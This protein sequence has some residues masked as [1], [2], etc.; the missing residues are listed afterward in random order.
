MSI[1][2]LLLILLL[3][4][5]W[6]GSFIMIKL[7]LSEIPPIFL[8]SARFFFTSFPAIFFLP[9]P[10]I[11]VRNI[12]VYGVIM[13]ALQFALFFVGMQM[14]V[15]PGLAAILMQVHVFFSLFLGIVVFR[16]KMSLL[17][18]IGALISF[19]GIILVGFH[20]KGVSS[21][22]GFFLIVIAALCWGAG[23]AISK[24]MGKVHILSLV[25]WGSMVAW[26]FLLLLSLV[27]EGPKTISTSFQNLTYVSLGAVIYLS[28]FATLFGFALWNW[29]LHHRPLSSVAPFTLLVPVVAMLFSVWF[30]HEPVEWWKILASSLV[31]GGLLLAFLGPY[32]QKKLPVDDYAI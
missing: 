24:K 2:H 16:E 22:Q 13:F 26:P 6:G 11:R 5:V 20:I 9:K 4:V 21:F 1:T 10:K 30:F 7:G 27:I 32:F 17:Q 8:A 3:V 23:S 31:I 18:M 29:L 12:V 28:Y 15:E 14:G 19:S 25:A